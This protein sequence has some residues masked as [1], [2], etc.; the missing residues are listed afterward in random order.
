MSLI[1]WETTFTLTTNIAS[2]VIIS[3]QYYRTE[4]FNAFLKS[5]HIDIEAV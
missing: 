4:K 2:N 1:F 5:F 3:E